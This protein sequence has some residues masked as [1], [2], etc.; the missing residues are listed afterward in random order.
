M[1]ERTHGYCDECR[2]EVPVNSLTGNCLWC[3]SPARVRK[4]RKV[5]KAKPGDGRL[6]RITEERARVLHRLHLEKDLSINELAGQLWE[7]LGYASKSS[8][9][10]AIHLAFKRHGLKAQDRIEMCR[11]KSTKHGL[12]PKHG[13]RPGYGTYKRKVLH[14]IEDQPL[15]AAELTVGPRK[16]EPCQMSSMKDS[17]FCE[18]HDSRFADR[19]ATHLAVVRQNRWEGDDLVALAPLTDWLEVR[20]RELG[21]WREVGRLVDRSASLVHAYGRGLSPMTKKPLDV[22]HR[23]TVEGILESAGIAFD[24]VYSG[25]AA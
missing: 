25:A 14:G 15:C 12:A 24:E 23:S 17:V 11:K 8:C 22:I 7:Q 16:G 6:S 1:S 13:P 20:H 2:E 4:V 19:R 21:S 9:S 18:S 5:A 10:S 3:N